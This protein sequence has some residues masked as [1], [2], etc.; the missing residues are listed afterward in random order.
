VDLPDI[1]I[2]KMPGAACCRTTSATDAGNDG[3]FMEFKILKE[4]L[5]VMVEIDGPVGL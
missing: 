2:N 5:I 3:W 1:K 4:S